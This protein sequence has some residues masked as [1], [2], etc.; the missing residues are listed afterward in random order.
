MLRSVTPNRS[1]HGTLISLDRAPLVEYVLTMH[2]PL[3]ANHST[4]DIAHI[5]SAQPLG[6][7]GRKQA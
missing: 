7:R 3:G 2:K 6:G 4:G 1:K 5:L